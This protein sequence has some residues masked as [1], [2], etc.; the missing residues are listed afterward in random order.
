MKKRIY[1]PICLLL[2]G[3]PEQTEKKVTKCDIRPVMPEKTTRR[4]EKG[5]TKR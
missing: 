1:V 4:K 2:W 5:K 3:V